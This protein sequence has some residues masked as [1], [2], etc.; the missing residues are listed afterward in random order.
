[1]CVSC[2]ALKNDATN[3]PPEDDEKV[4]WLADVMYVFYVLS[5]ALLV[6]LAIVSVLCIYGAA[7]GR[8]WFIL[9][10]VVVTFALLV[11]YLAGMCLSLWLM[12]IQVKAHITFDQGRS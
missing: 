1:M 12:G 7:K 2:Q 3:L 11:A 8:R 6:L 5:I 10:W 9:P 4:V